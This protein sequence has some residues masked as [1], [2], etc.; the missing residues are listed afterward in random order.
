MLVGEAAIVGDDRLECRLRVVHQIHFID[1]QH[2]ALDAEQMSE[3]AVPPRLR[4][5]AFARIDENDRQIRSRSARDHVAGVLLV[6]GRIGDDEFALLG[7]KVAVGDVDG[8][9]LFAL[10]G[11][12]VDQQ[13]KIDIRPCVPIRLLSAFNA[14]S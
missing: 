14:A 7:G 11:E 10:G 9:S 5:H 6:A 2:D 1:R 12:S 13:R 8:D 4:Q 3:V